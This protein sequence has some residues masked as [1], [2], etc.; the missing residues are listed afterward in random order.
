MTSQITRP[1]FFVP[2]A[3]H[4]QRCRIFN[5]HHSLFPGERQARRRDFTPSSQ[6]NS[7]LTITIIYMYLNM[8]VFY[9]ITNYVVHS[10]GT[11]LNCE[12]V[13]N[14]FTTEDIILLIFIFHSIIQA[15]LNSDAYSSS[16]NNSYIAIIKNDATSHPKSKF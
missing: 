6:R 14:R 7:D 8:C 16:F 4:H 3:A 10:V 11:F 2:M 5:R 15:M 12:C 9:G 1:I 13:E